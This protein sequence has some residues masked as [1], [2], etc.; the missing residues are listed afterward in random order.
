MNMT[1]YCLDSF[2]SCYVLTPLLFS[3]ADPDTGEKTI[4]LKP[5]SDSD[6]DESVDRA[7]L[8]LASSHSSDEDEDIDEGPK[9]EIPKS[10]KV[11]KCND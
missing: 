5:D 3:L 2:L 4:K 6:S 8:E 7:S 1:L 10:K 11:G 9:W